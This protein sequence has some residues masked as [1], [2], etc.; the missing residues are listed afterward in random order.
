VCD[1]PVLGDGFLDYFSISCGSRL[2][3]EEREEIS[4]AFE[5]HTCHNLRH[6]VRET[7]RSLQGFR[8]AIAVEVLEFGKHNPNSAMK[9]A[10][11]AL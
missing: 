1:V 7:H 11:T 3:T 2:V 4:L 9:R 8:K 10:A 5:V 6:G